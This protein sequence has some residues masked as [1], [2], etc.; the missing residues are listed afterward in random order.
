MNTSYIVDALKHM[1]STALR[2]QTDLA[3]KQRR[4]QVFCALLQ[5]GEQPDDAEKRA[6]RM[7]DE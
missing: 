2:V 4:V 5:A 7:E 1:L 6:A 3:R